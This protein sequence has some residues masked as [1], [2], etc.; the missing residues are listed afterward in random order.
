MEQKFIYLPDTG[1]L[2][3]MTEIKYCINNKIYLKESK[4]VFFQ[5]TQNDF[6]ILLVELT[7]GKWKF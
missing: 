6:K 1:L 5:I 4:D 2:I 7:N 3:D